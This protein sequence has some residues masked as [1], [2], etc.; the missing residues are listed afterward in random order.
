MSLG[1]NIQYLRKQKKITQ[2]MLADKMSVSRQTV[3]RWEADEIVPEL[4]NLVALSDLFSCK[5]D[6]LIRENL[7]EDKH[8]YSEITIKKVKGFRMARYVMI[9]PNPEDDVTA[10]MEN[11]AK[12][13]GLLES[14]PNAMQIG[15]DFPFVSIELQNRFALRGYVSAYVLPDGFTTDCP[16]VEYHDQ[17][18]ADYAVITIY[19][20]FVA[21]FERIP[22]AYKKIMA[23]LE[24]NGFQEKMNDNILACFEHVYEKDGM[25]CMDVYI[26]VDSVSK[27]AVFTIYS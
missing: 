5:L 4:N 27:T 18:D 23:Y 21:A 9:T 26:N 25:T 14:A 12:R 2:E 3:S 19:D 8:I 16:G 20:P 6:T 24:V 17:I 15:W 10:Y 13:S 11:W 1:K 22:N 7:T